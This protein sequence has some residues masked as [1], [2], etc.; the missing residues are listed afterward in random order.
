MAEGASASP[1]DLLA[2]FIIFDE[3]CRGERK[4]YSHNLVDLSN[5]STQDRID[6]LIT[7]LHDTIEALQSKSEKT[8]AHFCIGKSYAKE[9]KDTIFNPNDFDT[10]GL[11]G[12]KNRWT[13]KYRNDKYDGLVVLGAVSPDMLKK[14]CHKQVWDQQLYA[15]ALESAL[16][17]HFAYVVCDRRLANRS[18]SQGK[19]R[20]ELDPGYV[21]YMAFKYK[22][23][24]TL[25]RK[26]TIEQSQAQQEDIIAGTSQLDLNESI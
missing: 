3:L 9:K 10:W 19:L 14:E 22:I 8:I 16:I 12:I 7:N 1:T 18:F 6:A 20:E 26:E 17:T 5:K 21:V 15:I 13:S 4:G 24:L 11:K 25:R 23:K 2:D